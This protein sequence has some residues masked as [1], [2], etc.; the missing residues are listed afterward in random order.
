MYEI[1]TMF[2]SYRIAMALF[3]FSYRIGRLFP[4]EHIFFGMIFVNVEGLER[5]DSENDTRRIG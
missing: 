5:S 4:L 1:N 2:P 3:H